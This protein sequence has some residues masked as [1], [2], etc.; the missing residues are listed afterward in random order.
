MYDSVVRYCNP[1]HCL[2]ACVRLC[3]CVRVIVWSATVILC[4]VC[5]RMCVCACCSSYDVDCGLCSYP[6]P[7]SVRVC[8]VDRPCFR[9]VYHS[10]VW[11]TEY[12]L[13]ST[14]NHIHVPVC[15]RTYMHTHSHTY[16]PHTRT[17]TLT[18]KHPHT[19]T[20][21]HTGVLEAVRINCAGF[22]AKRP[23][24]DFVDHFWPLAPDLLRD[25]SLDDR[26]IA[27]AVV[28]RAGIQGHQLG[29]TKVCILCV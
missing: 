2:C 4:T 6:A 20:H 21:K 7:H 24:P 18:Q 8:I 27:R 13:C 3:V 22:P 9:S 14:H 15:P 1:V 29:T 16:P 11:S 12:E 26:S 10:N 19:Y 28:Q 25:T 17:H 23:Y 5:V